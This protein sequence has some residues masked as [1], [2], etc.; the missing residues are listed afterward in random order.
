MIES[1]HGF[2]EMTGGKEGFFVHDAST[3][4]YAF[5]P[6]LFRFKRAY[7]RIET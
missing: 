5:Y 2:K 4:A 1:T 3:I 7:V 6:E